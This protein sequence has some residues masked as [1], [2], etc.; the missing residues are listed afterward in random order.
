MG[1]TASEKQDIPTTYD[2]EGVADSHYLRI[3]STEKAMLEGLKK[4][5]SKV[6]VVLNTA[7]TMELGFLETYNVDA[8]VY[9]ATPGTYGTIGL[10]NVLLGKAC[11]SGHTSTTYAYDETICPAF[12]TY[13][14]NKYSNFADYSDI[15]TWSN[16]KVK[17]ADANLEYYYHYYEGI[18]VGYR[19]YETRYIG[20]DNAYSAA[21][22][23]SYKAAVQYPFGYGLSYTTFDWSSPTWTIGK[24]GGEIKATVDVKNVGDVAGKDV[25]ELYVTPPYTPDGIEKSAVVLEGYGKTKLLNPGET[26]TV[27]ITFNFDDMA[28]YDYKTAKCYV[29]DKGDY[30]LSLRSNAH[31]AKDG[32]T[33]TFTIADQIVYDE[34]NNGKRSSDQVAAVNQFDSVSKG[35]GSITYVSRHDWE[36]T[37]PKTLDSAKNI[38]ASAEVIAAIKNES[39]G[40]LVDPVSKDEEHLSSTADWIKTSQSNGVTVADYAG[41]TDYNSP[42]WD[43]LLD[44]MS[45]DE[46][47]ELYGDGAYRVA[48]VRSIGM[49]KTVDTDGPQGVTATTTGQYSTAFVAGSIW[50]CTWNQSLCEEIGRKIG[51]EFLLCGITGIYGP[52]INIM[53]TPF[54]G[55]NGE[56]LT[57]DGLLNGKT[58]AAYTRG[59]QEGGC[60]VYMKHFV[61]YGCASNASCMTWLNEQELRE[62]YLHGFELG[63]KEGQAHGMMVSF[64]RLGTGINTCNY[65][66]MNTVA[67]KEWGFVGCF[68]SD[69]IST[70][71]WDVNLGIRA[72]LNLI[73]DSSWDA[74]MISWSESTVD[75]STTKTNYGQHCLRECAKQLVYRYCNSAAS[76]AV[77]NWTPTWL[78][79]VGAADVLFLGGAVCCVIFLVKPAFFP[80]KKEEG[81]E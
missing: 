14:T 49:K 54:N 34:A 65:G 23:A 28:S 32:L 20:D 64:G 13:G 7:S 59:A 61:A 56:Y 66:L 11:P 18:Y 2:G 55:R 17:E 31:T 47:R 4:D 72:G 8:C 43:K 62:I 9:C 78:W 48:S 35:D 53:R 41:L 58:V 70:S 19:Y 46:M 45:I 15:N 29:L 27:T 25:V 50:A 21:E 63:V 44:E 3:V 67:R 33:K 74:Q 30:T 76:T 60:Y 26:D 39:N 68:V 6:I 40:A 79:I 38:A 77:R 37:M 42:L 51:H 10:G 73:L 69:G 16:K 52:S 24:Q 75:D 80:K 22:E 71:N 36:G 1:R 5:F 12:Y 81:K 57:E